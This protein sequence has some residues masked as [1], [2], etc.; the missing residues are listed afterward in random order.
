M[1]NDLV[2]P[3][4]TKFVDY[5][6]TRSRPAFFTP[7]T[8][9]HASVGL[10]GFLIFRELTPHAPVWKGFAVF[11]AIHLAYEL[12]DF[13]FSYLT[14]D[15][16][17]QKYTNSWENS[18]GDQL[19]ACIGFVVPAAFHLSALQTS[20]VIALLVV[21]MLSP[22]SSDSNETTNPMKIWDSVG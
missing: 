4:P 18:I 16:D 9:M 10:L 19:A 8:F 2:T 3:Q 20:G 5:R 17:T 21:I 22:L 13:Y 7:W 14:P 1:T 6:D 11:F 15:K 12:K